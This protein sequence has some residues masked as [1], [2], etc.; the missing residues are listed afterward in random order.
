[1]K[2]FSRNGDLRVGDDDRVEFVP[3]AGG[4]G[5]VEVFDVGARGAEASRLVIDVDAP[6]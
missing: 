6:S 5:V 4:E 1:V 3:D 2:A